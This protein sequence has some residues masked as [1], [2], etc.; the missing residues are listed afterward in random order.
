VVPAQQAL[1][2]PNAIIQMVE[3]LSEH[4]GKQET[5][6]LLN[7]VGQGVYFDNPPR[8]MVPQVEVAA[9]HQQLY[10]TVDCQEFKRLSAEAG[11]RTGDYLLAHRIPSPVQWMLKRLPDSIAARV[12][13]RAI[14][15]HAWTFAGSGVF[16]YYWHSSLMFSIT[17]NPITAGLHS[18]IPICDYYAGTF[19]RIFR[20]I[21][22]DNWRVVERTCEANGSAACLFEVCALTVATAPVLR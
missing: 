20:V 2:G 11:R 13:S 21:V 15:K 8:K 6:K 4:W 9:L 18:D 12:L 16:T 19:E 22:N 7:T 1:I 3:T 5:L 14:Q 10:G 17:G